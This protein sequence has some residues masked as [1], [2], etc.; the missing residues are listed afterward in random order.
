MI[1]TIAGDR[2]AYTY[3]PES[4]KRFPPPAGLARLM[5]EAGLE[6][7]RWTVLAGGIIA[8][9]SGRKPERSGAGG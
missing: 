4:V 7:I 5:D 3:L 9:H 6:S 2:D 1:G 8:I